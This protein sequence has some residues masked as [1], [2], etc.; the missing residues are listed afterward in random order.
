MDLIFTEHLQVRLEFVRLVIQ[1][2][3]PGTR[4]VDLLLRHEDEQNNSIINRLIH[5]WRKC[6]D[7]GEKC[8]VPTDL[9][10]TQIEE[11]QQALIATDEAKYQR[12]EQQAAAWIDQQVP[13]APKIEVSV[14]TCY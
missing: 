10:Y 1:V 6:R 4:A 5:A 11:Y 13:A 12:I 8:F 14:S 3:V 7:A 2:E 9:L